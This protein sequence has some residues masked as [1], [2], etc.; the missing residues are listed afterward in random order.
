MVTK[1]SSSL[2]ASVISKENQSK[3]DGLEGGKIGYCGYSSWAVMLFVRDG[4]EYVSVVTESKDAFSDALI[5]CAAF[6]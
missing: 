3:N 1:F 6:C 4:K 5:M 2:R